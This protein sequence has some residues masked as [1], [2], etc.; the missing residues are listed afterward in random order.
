[1]TLYTLSKQFRNR[2]ERDRTW[3]AQ[4]Y[5]R[6]ALCMFIKT[7]LWIRVWW[8]KQVTT[9]FVIDALNYI[10]EFNFATLQ[11]EE[12]WTS[13]TDTNYHKLCKM[14]SQYRISKSNIPFLIHL[15]PNVSSE[16]YG[17]LLRNTPNGSC[18][19]FSAMTTAIACSFACL[20]LAPERTQ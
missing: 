20:P 2:W 4:P 13:T 9:R 16:V 17:L 14:W 8:N 1:M 7:P 19:I 6:L 12:C 10:K 18:L 15:T 5:T 3:Q 11:V